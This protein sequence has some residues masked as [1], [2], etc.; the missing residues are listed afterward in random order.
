[1]YVGLL[2]IALLAFVITMALNEL[3]R[4]LVPWRADSYDRKR[5]CESATSMST[6][7]NPLAELGT[8]H[9][10]PLR[11]LRQGRTHDAAR[12]VRLAGDRRVL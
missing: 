7:G 9:V 12:A 10:T 1:M 5:Q 8:K 3:E 11:A 2:V 6:R 4:W